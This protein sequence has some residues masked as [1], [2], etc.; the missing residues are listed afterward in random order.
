MRLKELAKLEEIPKQSRT[1]LIKLCD[2][3]HKW[4]VVDDP[5]VAKT[6]AEVKMQFEN[7]VFK[8]VL[9]DL[10]KEID[11]LKERGAFIEFDEEPQPAPTTTTD[12]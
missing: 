10:Q 7:D 3:L 11:S 5:N 12:G 4:N 1:A 6:L 2:R 8:P 9:N